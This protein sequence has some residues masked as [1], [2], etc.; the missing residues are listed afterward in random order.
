MP[1]DYLFPKKL[2]VPG[3]PLETT[4]LNTALQVPAERLNGHLGPHNLRAPISPT[5]LAAADTFFKT[6]Q[7][8]V[9]VDS[10]MVVGVQS[11][12]VD[13]QGA[14]RLDQETSWQR[15]DGP[16]DDKDM[17]VEVLTGASALIV[18]AHAAHCYQGD[19][20]G[21]YSEWELK[22][23]WPT[24]DDYRQ[25]YDDADAGGV[26]HTDK[27][28]VW[29]ESPDPP[30]YITIDD[31]LHINLPPPGNITTVRRQIAR[32]IANGGRTHVNYRDY[33][34]SARAVDTS[35]I[36]RRIAAGPSTPGAIFRFQGLLGYTINM[37]RTKVGV[38]AGASAASFSALSSHDTT[39]DGGAADAIVYFPAQIQ[40]AF[41]VD[42]V[43]IPETIT[44]RFD[45]EQGSFAPARIVDPLSTTVSGVMVA[46]FY[47]RPDAVNI[48]MYTARLTATVN[49][50]PGLHTVELVVRRVPCGRRREF[51]LLSP[52]VGT[53]AT[54]SS[55]PTGNTVAIYSRQLSVTDAPVDPVGAATFGE[56]VTIAAFKDEDVVSREAL[57]D[58][59]LGVVVK[60]LNE[61]KPFQVA[62]GAVNGDH[63]ADYSSVISIGNNALPP[64]T[65]ATV[66][67]LVYPYTWPNNPPAGQ[68]FAYNYLLYQADAWHLLLVSK[69]VRSIPGALADPLNCVITVEGN[70]FYDRL[71]PVN[72]GA[73]AA[74]F[75]KELHLSAAVLCIGLKSGG[76][77]YLWR[78]SIVWANS[79]NYFAQQVNKAGVTLD[80]MQHL[81]RYE[82][83]GGADYVD[84][85]VTAT[86]TMSGQDEAN[87]RLPLGLLVSV[88]EVAIFASA[89]HMSGTA[90]IHAETR[91]KR[92]SINVMANKS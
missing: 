80:T 46:R 37:T 39:S 77:W 38:A 88:T 86:F 19:E 69:L 18:T 56:A 6:K 35:V 50:A 5:V 62:R 58:E 11:P 78:P 53:P 27:M 24:G 55:Q 3:E 57:V 72:T 28:D 83:Q 42:G 92:A 17:L 61:V 84:V 70:V 71:R 25:K 33:G 13:A 22:I 47:E 10:Q 91:V 31:E 63:L 64:L 8:F 49:V 23:P 41:R 74:A 21:D 89:L 87:P 45:N 48:P 40:Y 29:L 2:F 79:N 81:S 1:G 43:V 59:R 85:P 82:P 75:K 54:A 44:G 73:T 66:T 30:G 26:A 20:D 51:A 32:N 76:T 65:A 15:V 14:F 16:A 60:A 67:S 36:F 12:Q 9:E 4:E 52:G 90:G 7:V 68:A 34:Y